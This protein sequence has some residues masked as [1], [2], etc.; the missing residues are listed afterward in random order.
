[1]EISRLEFG[2]EIIKLADKYDFTVLNADTKCCGLENFGKKYPDRCF[3]FGIAE[4]NLF[5]AASGVA[6]AGEKVVVST[7][8]VFASMRACEQIRT[9]ICYPNL[10]VM[11]I[12]THAGLLT[13]ED[14]ATHI[15]SEDMAILRA[16]PNMTIVEPSD[17]IAARAL[18]EEALKFNGP[19]YIRFP[20]AATPV[21]HDEGY[22]FEI[23]KGKIICD[24]GNDAGIIAIGAMTYKA[25][26][27]AETLANEGINVKVLE[28]NTLK[29]LDKAAVIDLA[30]KTG[31]IV[32]VED[33]TIIG[34]LG[35]A[36]CETLSESYPV[37]VKRLGIQD[38][39]GE[40]GDPQKQYDKNNMNTQHIVA[41]VKDL[42]D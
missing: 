27:A 13:G 23:G 3:N 32:T 26:Q 42:L 38:C 19:L 40:S 20:K 2:K 33:H 7:F 16:F 6:N 12:A 17:V 8:A 34:G 24:R 18:A 41:A 30:K 28:I 21:I 14:G 39:F 15:A 29:P 10:N 11:I 5:A 9:F 31:K 35:S 37:P 22:K 1:M 4:Q 25:L 36:V